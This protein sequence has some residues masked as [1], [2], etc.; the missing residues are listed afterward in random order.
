MYSPE[1]ALD[2]LQ[3]KWKVSQNR[4]QQDQAR[5]AP[6]LGEQAASAGLAALMRARL[7]E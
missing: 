4:T 2:R 7:G 1:T 6:R 3:G 5:I